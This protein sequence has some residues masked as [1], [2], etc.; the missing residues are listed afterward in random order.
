MWKPRL[1]EVQP[2]AQDH[3]ASKGVE[4]KLK[5]VSLSPQGLRQ[6]AGLLGTTENPS[7][8][9]KRRLE[10]RTWAPEETDVG[11]MVALERSASLRGVRSE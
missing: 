11:E 10:I 8:F 1:R 7:D 6:I 9:Q 2:L 4:Y 5:T 3:T